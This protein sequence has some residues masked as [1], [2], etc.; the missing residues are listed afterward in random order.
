MSAPHTDIPINQSLYHQLHAAGCQ[1]DSHESD[2]YVKVTPESR[3]IVEAW[4]AKHGLS[5]ARTFVSALDGG[6]VWYDIPFMFAPW[7]DARQKGGSK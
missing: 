3:R 5:R 4:Q 7:W 1:L 2:L 6:G